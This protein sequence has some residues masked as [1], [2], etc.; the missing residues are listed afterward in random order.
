LLAFFV[1]A[2]FALS[3]VLLEQARPTPEQPVKAYEVF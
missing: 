3:A 2:G 1:G